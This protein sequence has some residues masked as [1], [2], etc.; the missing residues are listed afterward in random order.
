MTVKVVTDSGSDIPAEVAQELGISVIPLYV[1]FGES[2]YRDGIDLD[3]DEFYHE[4]V[5]NSDPPKTSAPPPGDFVQLYEQLAAE[6]DEIISIHLSSRYSSTRDV[7][8]L[9]R[10]YVKG[11]C[12]V[13]VVDSKSASMG[14]GLV[15][16]LAAR[17]ARSGESLDRVTGLVH[18]IIPHT[19]ILAMVTELKYVLGGKRIF[20]PK[21]RIFLGKIATLFNAKLLGEIYEGKVHAIG[22][23]RTE[24]KAF[25]RLE[26]QLKESPGIK[27]MAIM[28][29]TA[30]DWAGELAGRAASISPQEHLHLT[31]FGCV[32]GMQAG[33]RGVGV[34]FV[35]EGN[36]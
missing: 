26:K 17:A 23:F 22:I 14:L 34:A 11:K 12:R 20:L 25:D 5:R 8:M 18:E 30:P 13:E 16:I 35:E 33:P 6:T 24:E 36:P 28:H 31:R 27:E 3:A 21:M 4:L 1:R 7:A 10:D 15:A 9:A 19:H 2:I 29:T 32:T